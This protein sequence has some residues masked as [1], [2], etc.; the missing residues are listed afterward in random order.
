MT[1]NSPTF[2]I[3]NVSNSFIATEYGLLQVGQSMQVS[4]I[5]AG[6]ITALNN[7][8]LTVSP[9]LVQSNDIASKIASNP[10]TTLT[11]NTT[12]TNTG[13]ALTAATAEA[14]SNNN[15]SV[16]IVQLNNLKAQVDALSA[17]VAALAAGTY[18]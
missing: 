12:G 3:T 8:F 9:V 10:T 2:T 16:I 17:A 15:F 7:K 6:I 11:D 4:V 14:E 5:T 18:V 13:F 1:V